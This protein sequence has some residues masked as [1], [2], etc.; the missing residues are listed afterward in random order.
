MRTPDE[1]LAA[2]LA[3]GRSLGTAAELSGISVRSARDRANG[4]PF[5]RLVKRARR[6]L[7][8]RLL[9]TLAHD[10]AGRPSIVPQLAAT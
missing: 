5:Q 9:D 1:L 3:A 8:H 4:A 10:L 2:H 7:R 6:D